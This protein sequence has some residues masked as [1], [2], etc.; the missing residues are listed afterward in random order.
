MSEDD[1]NPP[2]DSQGNAP[3]RPHDFDGIQEFDNPMPNWW[4]SLLFM[5]ILFAFVYWAVMHRY[6]EET[7]P[8]KELSAQMELAT[9]EAARNAGVLSN[10]ILW[11][12]S[13]DSNVVKAGKEIYVASCAPCHLLDLAGAIGPNLKDEIWIHGGQ[14]LDIVKVITEGVS[15]KGMP[16]WGPILGRQKIAE[17]T[18]FILSHQQ[19]RSPSAP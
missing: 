17:V 12:M 11:G 3:V 1:S 8:G 19:P 14:P 18:A 7:D 9:Q 15:V 4:L 10:P 6:A 2:L 16:T 5:S 13:R